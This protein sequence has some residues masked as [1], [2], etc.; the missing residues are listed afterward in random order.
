MNID[1]GTSKKTMKIEVSNGTS[2]LSILED[3]AN[4]DSVEY[5]G[6]GKMVTGID[7]VAQDSN[8]SWLY[9]VNGKLPSIA[10]DKYHLTENSS[11]VFLYLSNN[12]AMKYFE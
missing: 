12:E 2:V 9:F 10:V 11:V 6:L 4:V 8:H 1:F 3:V 7:G 5:R